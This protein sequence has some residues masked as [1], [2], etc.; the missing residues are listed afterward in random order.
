MNFSDGQREIQRRELRKVARADVVA[1]FFAADAER[2]HVFDSADTGLLLSLI[3]LAKRVRATEAVI[4][5]ACD[6]DR[7]SVLELRSLDGIGSTRG[8]FGVFPF[9]AFEKFI[10]RAKIAALR[11]GRR[12]SHQDKTRQKEGSSHRFLINTSPGRFQG[13][14]FLVGQFL[15]VKVEAT[16]GVRRQFGQLEIF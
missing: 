6:F 7:D 9:H 15:V 14:V 10:R 11:K 4:A 12:N 5:R 1:E 13:S 2:A 8:G 16:N 3:K